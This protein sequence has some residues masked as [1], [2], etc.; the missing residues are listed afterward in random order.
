VVIAVTL[1]LED[2]F[3]EGKNFKWQRPDS[4]PSCQ[5]KLWGHGFTPRFFQGFSSGFWLRRFRCVNCKIVFTLRP[6]GFWH[7]L[8][9]SIEAIYQALRSRLEGYRW[10]AGTGRQR[11]RHWLAGFHVCLRFHAEWR[12]PSLAAALAEAMASGLRFV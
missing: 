11:A 5:G 8:Q 10:P 4:C 7:R 12:R 9:S 6:A 1:R 3:R 2:L